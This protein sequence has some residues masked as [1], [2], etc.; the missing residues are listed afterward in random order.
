VLPE[1]LIED[2]D[3]A[4]VGMRLV[5]FQNLPQVKEA[6][7]LRAHVVALRLYSTA[8]FKS[9]NDPLRDTGRRER[10]EAHPLPVTMTYIDEAVKRLRT[11]NVDGD[12]DELLW[13]GMKHRVLP[14][15]FNQ[16]GGT[17]LAPMSTT[18]NL[19]IALQYSACRGDAVLFC[20]HMSNFM[21]R[22][23]D[24]SFLSA[25]PAE[26]EILFPPLTYLKFMSVEEVALGE[27]CYQVVHVMPFLS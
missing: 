24:I 3:G 6:R 22:G 23:A 15:Q 13:R 4:T 9:L 17:E 12:V 11:L 27:C 19:E 25:F 21:T 2:D 14:L 10:S 5:D 18:Q 20:L 16:Q 26:R 1:R 8:A 7:L